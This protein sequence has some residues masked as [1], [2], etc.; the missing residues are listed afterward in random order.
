MTQQKTLS[1][2]LIHSRKINSNGYL[3]DDG[4]WDIEAILMDT[5]NYPF[6]SIERGELEVGEP[7]HHMKIVLTLDNEFN[8]VAAIAETLAAPFNICASVPEK[9]SQLVGITIG[10]GWMKQVNVHLGGTEGCTHLNEM[11]KVI[12]T[13]AFQTVVP[14]LTQKKQGAKIVHP[15]VINSCRGWAADGEVVQKHFPE[16]IQKL[17]L[18]AD[19]KS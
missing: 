18:N 8:I 4:L 6:A 2:Q 7:V 17:S 13:T 1:R 12:A 14:Y 10:P 11:L 19:Q 15:M 16:L 9:F 5:K 3:R